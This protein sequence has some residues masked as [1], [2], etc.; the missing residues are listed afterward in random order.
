MTKSN[1]V[2]ADEFKDP[3]GRWG[4]ESRRDADPLSFDPSKEPIDRIERSPD[5]RFEFP[6]KR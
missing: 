3:S 5:D 4:G 6:Y 1:N 2:L